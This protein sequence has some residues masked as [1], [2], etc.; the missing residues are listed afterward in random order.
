VK[1]LGPPAGQSVLV[2]FGQQ[3]TALNHWTLAETTLFLHSSTPKSTT[4]CRRC[5]NSN[6]K[7]IQERK[8]KQGECKKIYFTFSLRKSQLSAGAVNDL[9]E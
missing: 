1:T 7:Y 6:E 5:L 4:D 2:H 8:E 9:G 3:H